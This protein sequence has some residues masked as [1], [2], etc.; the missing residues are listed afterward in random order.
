MMRTAAEPSRRL[1]LAL[2]VVTATLALL[3]SLGC[4]SSPVTVDASDAASLAR[5]TTIHVALAPRPESAAP[6]PDG[7]VEAAVAPALESALLAQAEQALEARGYAIGSA[8]DSDLVLELA[9]REQTTVRRTWSSDPDATA[10]QRVKKTEAVVEIRA[11]SASEGLELW[12]CEARS[13]LPGSARS[14]G[15]RATEVWSRILSR[16]LEPIPDR[17]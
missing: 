17:R 8:A 12:R 7:T 10:S 6:N 13:R 15:A 9:P 16:A 11:R 4:V 14:P 5:S 3:P 1:G 2:T